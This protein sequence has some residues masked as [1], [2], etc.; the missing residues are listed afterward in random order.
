MRDED[1]RLDREPGLNL[2]G[3]AGKLLIVFHVTS[4]RRRP[5]LVTD[6]KPVR[7]ERAWICDLIFVLTPNA[8]F[9]SAT[10]HA[11]LVFSYR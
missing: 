6:Q 4:Q 11:R 9:G 3:Q 1:L 5:K 2:I 8:L 7:T 10:D